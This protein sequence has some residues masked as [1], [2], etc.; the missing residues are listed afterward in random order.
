MAPTEIKKRKMNATGEKKLAKVYIDRITKGFTTYDDKAQFLE[1]CKFDPTLFAV[2][3]NSSVMPD[4]TSPGIGLMPV[5]DNLKVSRDNQQCIKKLTFDD[6]TKIRGMT[7]KRLGG[8][9][10]QYRR[11]YSG[12]VWDNDTP[13]CVSAL[14]L[15]DCEVEEGTRNKPHAEEVELPLKVARFHSCTKKLYSK[16][17][18][19]LKV[20]SATGVSTLQMRSILEAVNNLN[21]VDPDYEFETPTLIHA[22]TILED[23]NKTRLSEAYAS[24]LLGAFMVKATLDDRVTAFLERGPSLSLATALSIPKPYTKTIVDSDLKAIKKRKLSDL[25][26]D[27]DVL[28]S[29]LT[30]TNQFYSSIRVNTCDVSATISGKYG[31]R[32]GNKL[33]AIH[34]ATT[35][36][37]SKYQEIVHAIVF[38]RAKK[39][40]GVADNLL[41][42]SDDGSDTDDATF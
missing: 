5:Y 14:M 6:E 2:L 35:I 15:P 41:E 39:D 38:S 33:Q 13:E 21:R 11:G 12:L 34:D 25:D 42:E 30:I 31:I 4:V 26:P 32:N 22:T 40:A 1:A 23:P 7:L 28:L 9:W 8:A 27:E 19:I 18:D 17:E 36:K 29:S 10:R 16:T 37:A 20:L 3:L 24:S